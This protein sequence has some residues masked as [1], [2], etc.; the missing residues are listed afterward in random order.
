MGI[1][2][3]EFFHEVT[4]VISTNICAAISGWSLKGGKN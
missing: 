4:D 3:D 2:T 1:E